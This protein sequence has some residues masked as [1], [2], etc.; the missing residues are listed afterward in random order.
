ML[1]RERPSTQAATGEGGKGIA[2]ETRSSALQMSD[3]LKATPDECAHGYAPLLPGLF[4]SRQLPL[5]RKRVEGSKVKRKSDITPNSRIK[6]ALHKLWLQSRER[7][8]AIRRDGYICQHC[9]VKQ[10]TAKGKEQ[11]VVVHHLDGVEWENILA[12]IRRHLLV[13]PRKLVTLCPDCHKREHIC[14]EADEIL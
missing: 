11:K 1:T 8:A 2:P 7:A 10:S 13:E 4:H 14:A 12:Y 5:R 9:G 6:A 3:V